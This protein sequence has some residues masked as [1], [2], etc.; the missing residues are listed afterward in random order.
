[1]QKIAAEAKEFIRTLSRQIGISPRK[2]VLYSFLLGLTILILIPIITFAW[3]FRDLT[4]KE[5]IL[6]RKNAG[7][8][9]LDREDKPFFS[10]Y[11]ARRK[12]FV[13]IYYLGTAARL[14]KL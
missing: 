6:T 2:L 12:S 11:D 9:L 4:S 8:I 1:M 5:N 13:S 7:I 3:Y 10:F 14:Y